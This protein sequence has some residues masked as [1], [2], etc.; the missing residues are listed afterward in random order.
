MLRVIVPGQG[1][2][3]A[4]LDGAHRRH[5]QSSR[6]TGHNVPGITG[7]SG[8]R[9]LL[10]LSPVRHGGQPQDAF[11]WASRSG[12]GKPAGPTVGLAGSPEASEETRQ[13]VLR[14]ADELGYQPNTAAPG[15]SSGP[16][17]R[18]RRAVH[19][20]PSPQRRAGR[21]DLS[22][23]RAAGVGH[24]ARRAQNAHALLRAASA[25]GSSANPAADRDISVG[26]RS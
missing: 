14:A 2:G 8:H 1:R 6:D 4:G 15:T 22:V 21:S 19:A 23:S 16:Q 9:Q 11:L 7:T 20:T 24:R 12:G 18:R 17:R 26:A 13:P 25:A 10:T 3:L 5:C